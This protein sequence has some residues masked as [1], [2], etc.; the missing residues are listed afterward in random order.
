MKVSSM[1]NS[2][3]EYERLVARILQGMLKYDGF[4]TLRVEHDI[5]LIGKSGATHQI[6]VFWEF[7]AAGTIYRTCVECKNYSSAVKKLHVAAFAATLAD[8]GNAN[9]IIA[10]TGSFQ[11][12]AKLLA[13]Q[14]NIRLVLVNNL[15]KTIHMTMHPKVTDYSNLSLN[16]DQDS[17]R[18]ALTRNGL[19]QFSLEWSTTGEHPLLDA[20]GTP[21]A[22]FN[23]VL[24]KHPK[25][26]GRN[27]VEDI[28]LYLDVEGLGLVL[29]ESIDFDVRYMDLPPMES[30]IESPNSAV[31]VIE[32]IVGDNKHYL[33]DDGSVSQEINNA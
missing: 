27:R 12:G 28:G 18:D 26:E 2:N 33:H 22:T 1:A 21:V 19:E 13:E 7:K 30:I 20:G 32:E 11:K 5:T 17:I 6:D 31:A 3:T 9:G 29:L 25:K 14:N 10:T 23:T 8:I 4:E 15:I 16:F 24:N